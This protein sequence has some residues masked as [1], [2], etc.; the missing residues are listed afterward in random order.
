MVPLGRKR[1]NRDGQWG[2]GATNGPM[3]PG[4]ELDGTRWRK[5]S[6]GKRT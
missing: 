3:K 6:P 1:A 4:T 5:G 2:V